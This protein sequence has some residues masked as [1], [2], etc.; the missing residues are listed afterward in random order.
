MQVWEKS[1]TAKNRGISLFQEWNINPYKYEEKERSEYE[2]NSGGRTNSFEEVTEKLNWHNDEFQV[3]KS[4][5]ERANCISISKSGNIYTVGFQRSGMGKNKYVIF[6]D[7]PVD[8]IKEKFNDGCIYTYFQDTI[9]LEYGGGAIGM[10][11]FEDYY[12]DD[13]N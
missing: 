7:W 5:L 1:D 2:I 11:C 6:E 3:L 8:E 9:A 13:E 12:K 10:Q 4:K